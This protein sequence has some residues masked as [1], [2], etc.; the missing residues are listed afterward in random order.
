[1]SVPIADQAL[2]VLHTP[3]TQMQQF[4]NMFGFLFDHNKCCESKDIDR[5]RQQTKGCTEHK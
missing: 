3:F 4:D 1:M 5:L 2:T